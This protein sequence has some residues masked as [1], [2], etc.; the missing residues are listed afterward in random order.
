MQGAFS[1]LDFAAMGLVLGLALAIWLPAWVEARP[2]VRVRHRLA[3][4]RRKQ[5]PAGGTAPTTAAGDLF[6]RA[7]VDGLRRLWTALSEKGA[8]IGGAPILRSLAIVGTA[9]ALALLTG[10]RALDWFTP[11]PTLALTLLGTGIFL[12]VAWNQLQR[13]WQIRFLDNFADAIDLLTRAVRSGLPVTEAIRV[14]GRDVGEPVGG[15]FQK[16]ADALDLGI[17]LKD[18]LRQAA[19][20]IHLPDFD[21]LV[22]TLVLQRESGGQ[23]AETLDGLSTILRRRKELRLKMRA[24]TAEGRMSALIVSVLPILSGLGMY[25]VDPDYVLQLFRTSL[26]RTLLGIGAGCLVLGTIVVRHMTRARP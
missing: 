15:E 2:S 9:S 20:R 4:V 24:L 13:R 3:G 7:D 21:F 22:V 12:V 11:L 25:L 8:R 19:R 18:A 23:L 26:G 10:L 16:I 6:A 1:L 14:A 5:Q 17:D